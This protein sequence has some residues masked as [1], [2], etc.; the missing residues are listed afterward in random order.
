M[1]LDINCIGNGRPADRGDGMD[2][3][4]KG[5]GWKGGEGAEVAKD[6]YLMQRTMERRSLNSDFRNS[7]NGWYINYVAA[8]DDT[9]LLAYPLPAGVYRHDSVL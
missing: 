2:G 7:H 6:F 4:A 5:H 3:G 8:M 9:L 1:L